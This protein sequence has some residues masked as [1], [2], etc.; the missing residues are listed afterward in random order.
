MARNK[1][2]GAS[3]PSLSVC[4]ERDCR[5]VQWVTKSRG[6]IVALSDLCVEHANVPMFDVP[7]ERVKPRGRCSP[8]TVFRAEVARRRLARERRPK[9]AA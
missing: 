3:A 8:A 9:D 6:K 4:A 7:V 2:G 5:R 1:G